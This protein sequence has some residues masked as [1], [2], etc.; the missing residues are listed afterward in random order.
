M[1]SEAGSDKLGAGLSLPTTTGATCVDSRER[2]RERE[3]ERERGRGMHPHSEA[4]AKDMNSLDTRVKIGLLHPK[5]KI[6]DASAP[7][8][9]SSEP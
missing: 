9:F 1:H 7:N 3:G 8:D 4:L 2:E 6:W 5:I